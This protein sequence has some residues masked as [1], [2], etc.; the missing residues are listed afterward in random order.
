MTGAA[1]AKDASASPQPCWCVSPCCLAL[2]LRGCHLFD[3]CMPRTPIFFVGV[4]Q[5]PISCDK[6]CSARCGNQAKR[7]PLD[8]TPTPYGVA[9]P[10][11]GCF[12]TGVFSNGFFSSV[13]SAP[14]R[15]PHDSRGRKWGRSE[16][17]RD[18][19][20]NCGFGDGERGR[21]EIRRSCSKAVGSIPT[22]IIKSI[23]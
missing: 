16:E 11:K 6:V 19:V 21:R 2:R 9:S 22:T 1:K 7:K 5:T 14:S 13:L 8:K 10:T 20:C 12:S 4:V 18:T 23:G 17:N 15:T 3:G